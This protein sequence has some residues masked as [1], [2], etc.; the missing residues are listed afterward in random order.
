MPEYI[1]IGFF[2]RANNKNKTYKKE[3][4]TKMFF[5]PKN[6]TQRNANQAK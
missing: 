2:T 4:E 5:F 3:K 6:S 1:Y